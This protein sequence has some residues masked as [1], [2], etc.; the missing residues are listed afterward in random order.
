M[1]SDRTRP[2]TG[3]WTLIESLRLP[4]RELVG[5]REWDESIASIALLSADLIERLYG[6]TI[7]TIRDFAARERQSRQVPGAAA[8]RPRD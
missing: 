8:P 5:S 1:H 3:R 2:S 6:D 4:L 7:A